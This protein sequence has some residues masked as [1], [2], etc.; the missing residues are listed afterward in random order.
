MTGFIC[1]RVLWVKGAWILETPA[2]AL[3]ALPGLPGA[4]KGRTE[5]QRLHRWPDWEPEAP[6]VCQL[7]CWVLGVPGAV[8]LDEGAKVAVYA[9]IVALRQDAFALGG[10][11]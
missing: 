3:W 5:K 7:L 6:E 4:W 8:P 1:W 9:E 11:P 2:G 10:V